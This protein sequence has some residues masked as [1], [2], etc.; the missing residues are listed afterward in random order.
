MA[1]KCV[2]CTDLEI[3]PE[4]FAAKVDLGTHLP[5]HP[6]KMIDSA[7]F[8]LFSSDWSAKYVISEVFTS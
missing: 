5:T 1:I 7:G 3:C 6:Y 4:C 2:I 8:Q